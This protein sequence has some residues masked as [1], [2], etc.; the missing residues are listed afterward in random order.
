MDR[1]QEV[2]FKHVESEITFRH[3]GGN[4]KQAVGRI[5]LELEEVSKLKTEMGVI[6]LPGGLKP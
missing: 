4:V 1:N 5:H 3:P 2:G 6:S